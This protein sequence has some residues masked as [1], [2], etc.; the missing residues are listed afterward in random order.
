MNIQST[1]FSDKDRLQDALSSQKFITEGYNT[2]SN[3]CATPEVRNV[4]LNLLNEE[5]T[6]QSE[7][8]TEMHSRGWYQPEAAQQQKISQVKTKFGK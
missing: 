6:I 1:G 2:F 3:E 7:V 8:F 4:F 5:H